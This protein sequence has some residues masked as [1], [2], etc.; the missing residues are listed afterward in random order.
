MIG[1]GQE[2]LSKPQPE[3]LILNPLIAMD[4]FAAWAPTSWT[5]MRVEA[6]HLPLL[7]R[8]LRIPQEINLPEKKG[9]VTGECACLYGG[10]VSKKF[11]CRSPEL[12][13]CLNCHDVMDKTHEISF[14]FDM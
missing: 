5:D 12:S 4:T 2:L 11:D 1:K 10:K 14:A 3:R 7:L 6:A 8:G 9:K 13:D